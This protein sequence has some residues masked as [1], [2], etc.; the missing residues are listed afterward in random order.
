MKMYGIKETKEVL[1]LVIAIAQSVKAAGEDGKFSIADLPQ[2]IAPLTLI[3]AAIT[4]INMVPKEI[5]ELDDEEIA[6]LQEAIGELIQEPTIYKAVAK[7]IEFGD[8]ILE[9]TGLDLEPEA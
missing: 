6:E 8:A 5:R 1:L 4:D 7:F 3:P 2:F 9:L